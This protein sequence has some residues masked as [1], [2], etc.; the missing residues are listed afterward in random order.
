MVRV[1]PS[2]VL[3]PNVM[4]SML[5]A[6]AKTLRLVIRPSSRAGSI[7]AEL[8]ENAVQP[9]VGVSQRSAPS[10]DMLIAVQTRNKLRGLAGDSKPE[11][12]S[13]SWCRLGWG[14]VVI[15]ANLERPHGHGMC[16]VAASELKDHVWAS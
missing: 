3:M 14:W 8:N 11:V 15:G 5:P 2:C 12:G 1:V 13:C 16:R 4:A 7:E 10:W 9:A 6:R